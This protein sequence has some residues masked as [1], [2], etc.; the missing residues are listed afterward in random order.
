MRPGRLTETAAASRALTGLAVVASI[1]FL[2]AWT[3]KEKRVKVTIAD[4]TRQTRVF[5]PGGPYPPGM[6]SLKENERAACQSGFHVKAGVR[7][8]FQKTGFEPVK[9]AA[10]FSDVDVETGLAIDIWLPRGHTQAQIDH[11]EAHARI[12]ERVYRD[13]AEETARRLGA[14]FLG[15]KTRAFL[16]YENYEK[17]AEDATSE[18]AREISAEWANILTAEAG[19][20]NDAFDALT[21]HGR[22]DIPIEQAI[23][24]AFAKGRR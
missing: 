2:A 12:S 5:E 15:R 23:E 24:A 7:C 9:L 14:K 10:Q 17:L 11:E 8:R 22:K 3:G 1:C 6:P 16:M 21:D 19:R 18:A 4:P 20:V 13:L